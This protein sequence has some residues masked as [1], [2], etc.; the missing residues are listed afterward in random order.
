M[1]ETSEKL[2]ETV[3]R[4][5]NELENILQCRVWFSNHTIYIDW[6]RQAHKT[7]LV[8]RFIRQFTYPLRSW[9]IWWW[10]NKGQVVGTFQEECSRWRNQLKPWLSTLVVL[11]RLTTH[12]VNANNVDSIAAATVKGWMSSA[13]QPNSAL[14]SQPNTHTSYVCGQFHFSTPLLLADV[15]ARQ[16][17]AW[18]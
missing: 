6:R 1:W 8:C 14:H 16:E 12:E 11:W 13:G 17:W 10:K 5:V 18:G 4:S 7:I 9:P 15:I 3:Q 2:F